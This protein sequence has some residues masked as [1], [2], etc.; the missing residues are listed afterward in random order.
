MK[1]VL[2]FMT[3]PKKGMWVRTG[4]YGGLLVENMVQAISRDIM[5]NGMLNADNAGLK[6]IGT[7]HDEVI[8]EKESEA[9]DDLGRLMSTL[10]AWAAGCPI[11]T[12]GFVAKRYRKG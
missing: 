8:V 6:I 11:E 9:P 4:S 2:T 10:P 7:V 5:V 12:E 3:Q 1:Q